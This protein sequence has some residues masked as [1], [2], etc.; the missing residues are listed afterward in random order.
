MAPGGEQILPDARALVGSHW[1]VLRFVHRGLL[2]GYRH[3]QPRHGFGIMGQVSQQ[4]HSVDKGIQ[5]LPVD[6]LVL[7][8]C[9]CV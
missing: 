6:I 4:R 1:R 5:H 2:V 8:G 7:L 9:V 3:V